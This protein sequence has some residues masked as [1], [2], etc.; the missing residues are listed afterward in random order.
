MPDL[1]LKEKKHSS[2][3]R[4]AKAQ[5]AHQ[6]AQEEVERAQERV[7]RAQKRMEYTLRVLH[8]TH[9]EYATIE[10]IEEYYLKHACYEEVTS[11]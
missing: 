4:L 7:K 5:T 6:K 9:S 3:L 1:Q 11:K 2:W 10:Y 8:D